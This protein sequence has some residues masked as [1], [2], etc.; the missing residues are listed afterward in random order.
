MLDLD[1]ET[2]V[3]LILSGEI[4]CTLDQRRCYIENFSPQVIYDSKEVY[5][6][7]YRKAEIVGAMTEK[8]ALHELSTRGMWNMYDDQLLKELPKKIEDLKVQLY[9]AFYKF[10]RREQVAKNLKNAKQQFAGL[11]M[12]R[13][14]Y[15]DQTCE[16]I[17]DL[18]RKK[19]IIGLSTVNQNYERLYNRDT[20]HE[21]DDK[22]LRRLVQAYYHTIPTEADMR[23][24][25]QHEPWRGI[26]NAS[27]VEHSLFGMPARDLTELQRIAIMWSRI[28]DNVHEHPE[29]PPDDLIE[30]PDMFDGWLIVQGR[31]REEEKKK[32]FGEKHVNK[33]RGADEVFVMVEDVKDIQRVTDMMTPEAKIL[34][35]QRMKQLEKQGVVQEQ[36]MV[37]SKL[38]IRQQA[39]QQ[40]RDQIAAGKKGRR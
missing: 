4:A 9:D 32:Q 7:T 6:D 1:R 25:V 28:Y 2:R 33:A 24:M 22:K 37:D 13:N 3:A 31:K 15:R 27:K 8:E 5:D 16:G 38:K 20:I 14:E 30:D 10:K 21:A 39:M 19:Y 12:R 29:C 40:M 36:H 17:A 11:L 26:W 23:D 34:K 35:A 18:A